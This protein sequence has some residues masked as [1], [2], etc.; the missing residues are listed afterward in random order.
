M[1]LKSTIDSVEN[2]E[3]YEPGSGDLIV[4]TNIRP[5]S[6]DDL[7]TI[8]SPYHIAYVENS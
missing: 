7:N 8:K 6:L 2:G 4:F 5:K 3:N 1:Q